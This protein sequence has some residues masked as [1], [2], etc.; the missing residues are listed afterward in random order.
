MYTSIL[1][2]F[3]YPLVEIQYPYFKQTMD[4]L[5]TMKKTQWWKPEELKRYQE[6]RLQAVLFHAYTNVPYYHKLFKTVGFKPSK[7]S[8]S[9]LGKLPILTKDDIR[10]N[11]SNLTARNYPTYNLIP[12]ATGGSTGEPMKF[13]IDREWITWNMAAAYRQWEWANYQIGDK[14][15]YLWSSPHDIS[16]QEDLKNRIFNM[17]QRTIYLDALR[18]T[19]K[20][21]NDYIKTLRTYK[22]K[23]INAY[24]SAIFLMAQYMKKNNISN[25]KPNSILTSCDMLFRNQRKIIEEVFNC[26]VFDYYSGREITFQAGECP[27][28]IG[29]H[30]A[31]ENAVV[32]FIKDNEIVSAGEF[33]KIII[34]DLSN[35]AMPFIRYEIGDLGKPSDEQCPC[36]RNLPLMKEISG[37]TRD[38][39]TTKKG[40][41]LTGAFFSTLF[42]DTKGGTKGIKQFQFIQQTKNH[43]ILKIVK[44]EDFSHIELEKIIE[45][46]HN[47]CDDMEIEVEFVE[48]IL[49]QPSGKYRSIISEIEDPIGF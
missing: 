47:Q 10:K 8:F 9:D 13:F 37:R 23:V 31:I 28:H 6:K 36:G 33:G 49:P 40:K 32:E 29:Y 46:I 30:M 19:E 11:I 38:I 17:F 12:S 18:L 20:K 48:A 22:P 34:T 1:K 39:I 7:A 16:Q 24:S 42:Y 45:K 35:Y 25:I 4:N 2:K 26:Q 5:A 14:I 3:I 41:Y 44:A 15:V 21:M 43:L 27:E